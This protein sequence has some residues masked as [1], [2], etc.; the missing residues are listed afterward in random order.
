MN[1]RR[2]LPTVFLGPLRWIPEF[3]ELGQKRL[4]STGRLMGATTEIRTR[5]IKTTLALE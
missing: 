5:Q 3:L 2:K 4:R 1:S